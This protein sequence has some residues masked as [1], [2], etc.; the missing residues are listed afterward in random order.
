MSGVGTV[1]IIVV[2]PPHAPSAPA[3]A[4]GDCGGEHDRQCGYS[5]RDE[6]RHI[7]DARRTP[8]E[9]RVWRLAMTNHRVQRVDGF[10]RQGGWHAADREIQEGRHDA[11][12]RTFPER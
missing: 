10:V 6:V 3:I 9:V 4:A 5:S 1:V 2:W 12:A 7:I 8:A 11:L